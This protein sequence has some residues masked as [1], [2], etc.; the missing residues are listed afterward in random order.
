MPSLV[1]DD[2]AYPLSVSPGCTRAQ[3]I[4][5]FKTNKV[6]I[7]CLEGET[8]PVNYQFMSHS[9]TTG[10]EC[11]GIEPFE[12]STYYPTG[13]D[14]I[15]TYV[16]AYIKTVPV[17]VKTQYFWNIND[18][19][20]CIGEN[21]FVSNRSVDFNSSKTDESW[22]RALVQEDTTAL[23]LAASSALQDKKGG[24]YAP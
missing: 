2:D 13:I 16:R 21:L 11:S 23:N 12:I 24:W 4:Y 6:I 5:S 1:G 19:D 14:D 9:A 17:E 8:T 22:I 20:N 10:V 15:P 7:N 18:G 3:I